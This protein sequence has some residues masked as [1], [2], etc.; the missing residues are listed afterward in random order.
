MIEIQVS[1]DDVTIVLNG[2]DQV[3]W[4]H[5]DPNYGAYQI[6]AFLE[7]IGLQCKVIEIT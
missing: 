5:E 1:Y 7:S 4:N 6:K 3:R 2:L